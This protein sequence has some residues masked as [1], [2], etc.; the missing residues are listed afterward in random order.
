MSGCLLISLGNKAKTQEASKQPTL[1]NAIATSATTSSVES[2]ETSS[3][4]TDSCLNNIINYPG[5]REESQIQAGLENFVTQMESMTQA[6]AGEVI[7]YTTEDDPFTVVEFYRQNQSQDGWKETLYLASQHGGIIVW[8]KESTSI[9]VFIT[10]D[11]GKTVVLLGC[12]PVLK[13]ADTTPPPE[14]DSLLDISSDEIGLVRFEATPPEPWHSEDTITITFTLQNTSN[15]TITFDE[16]GVFVGC[17]RFSTTDDENCDFGHQ[18]KNYTLNAGDMLTLQAETTLDVS[19]SWHFWPAY[20]LNGGYGPF[21][22][23]EM[24]VE[25]QAREWPIYNHPQGRFGFRYPPEWE[26]I[27]EYYYET[28]AGEQS[29]YLT[30]ILAQIGNNDPNEEIIINPRQPQCEHGLCQEIGPHLILTYSEHEYV[31]KVFE[32]I[33]ASFLMGE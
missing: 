28:A 16:Y 24:I 23:Q 31:Q 4:V 6:T 27:D 22:W 5:A 19:G 9:Q 29:P 33:V 13:T 20:H 12:G 8:E 18:Y 17:R 30:V 25:V 3:P 21:K 14:D 15:T 26:I 32:R 2:S 11:E 7:A 10:Y 1:A